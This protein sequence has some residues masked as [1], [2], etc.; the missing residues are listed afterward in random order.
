MLPPI[1]L[2][3]PVVGTRPPNIGNALWHAAAAAARA[4][5]ISPAA[6]SA[7]GRYR[8][9]GIYRVKFNHVISGEIERDFAGAISISLAD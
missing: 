9:A 5:S 6:R 8:R 3:L 2:P 4:P 7:L 1:G